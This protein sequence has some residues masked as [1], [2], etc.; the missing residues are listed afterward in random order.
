MMRNLSRPARSGS[1]SRM[2]DLGSDAQQARRPHKAGGSGKFAQILGWVWALAL[3]FWLWF[4]QAAAI[5]AIGVRFLE[6]VIR[7]GRGGQ[8]SWKRVTALEQLVV[9]WVLVCGLSLLVSPYGCTRPFLNFG[10]WTALAGLGAAFVIDRGGDWERQRMGMMIVTAL[11][12]LYALAQHFTGIDLMRPL[13]PSAVRPISGWPGHHL[14]VGGAERHM[15]Y[16]I[17]TGM[18]GCFPLAHLLMSKRRRSLHAVFVVCVVL[19]LFASGSRVA[20][21]AFV[22]AAM[23]M[24]FGM[25]KKKSAL[26]IVVVLALGIGTVM[27]VDSLQAKLRVHGDRLLEADRVKIWSVT[28]HLLGESSPFGIGYGNFRT[29][30]QPV[31]EAYHPE[32]GIRSGTHNDF[33]QVLLE[34]GL[35]GAIVW[36]LLI[37]RMWVLTREIRGPPG[38]G[39]DSQGS[40][41]ADRL[42]MRGALVLLLISGFVHNTLPDGEVAF[43]LWFLV[44]VAISWER[45]S[46]VN[47]S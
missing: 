47:I 37:G 42:A 10:F 18:L 27:R 16:G 3:P 33:L 9:A 46:L 45:E 30:S 15:T 12:A 8:S 23:V 21:P 11:V 22:A 38:N 6:F 41:P 7:R 5:G 19:G 25:G 2:D 40:R 29:V 32:V 26:L 24:L 36:I 1:C 4:V 34:T 13:G 43:T 17:V 44:G 28:G 14:A 31:F 20:L 35:V 39:N